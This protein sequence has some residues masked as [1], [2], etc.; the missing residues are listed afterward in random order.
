MCFLVNSRW[1]NVINN[2]A[3]IMRRIPFRPKFNEHTRAIENFLRKPR[4]LELYGLELNALCTQVIN[5]EFVE[6]LQLNY[7]NF[8]SVSVFRCLLHHSLRLK[9][10]SMC[11]VKIGRNHGEVLQEENYARRNLDFLEMRNCTYHHLDMPLIV[12]K[13]LISE[14]ISPKVFDFQTDTPNELG[15]IEKFR[16]VLM[17]IHQHYAKSLKSLSIINTSDNDLNTAMDMLKTCAEFK[18]RKLHI[19][20]LNPEFLSEGF[21]R[22]LNNQIELTHFDTSYGCLS[23]SHLQTL[24]SSLKN[25]THLVISIDSNESFNR[26]VPRLEGVKH[27]QLRTLFHEGDL[28][29]PKYLETL[30]ISIKSK[31]TFNLEAPMT[32]LRN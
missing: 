24:S 23:D 28:D 19:R 7:C 1:F 29:L 13:T 20:L 2:C 30:D 16:E 27:L 3:A 4:I 9:H 22:F 8:A 18:L 25:L 21:E 14:K 12:L 5:L 10:L 11:R 32:P 26:C 6:K 31:I 17:F 15:D